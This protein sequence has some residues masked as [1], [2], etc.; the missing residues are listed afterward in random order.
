MDDALMGCM[1]ARRS[2]GIRLPVMMRAFREPVESE[3]LTRW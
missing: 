1:F 3:L 2:T